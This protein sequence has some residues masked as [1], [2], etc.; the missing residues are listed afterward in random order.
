MPDKPGKPP[1][2]PGGKPDV[3]TGPGGMKV[4]G[5]KV[6]FTVIVLIGGAVV[7]GL[8]AFKKKSS[9]TAGSSEE[10]E[11]GRQAF[12]PVTAEN[13]GGV[14]A[15]GGGM[16]SGNGAELGQLLTQQQANSEWLA[17]FLKEQQQ[18][19]RTLYE[20]LSKTLSGGGAPTSTNPVGV[21]NAPPQNGGTPPAAPNPPP[22]HSPAPVS[23]VN[24]K[25]GNGCAGHEYPHG[26]NGKGSRTVECQ[27]K[28]NGKC[29]W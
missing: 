11:L 19:N 10:A 4:A 8:V 22:T 25:C 15:G 3:K 24:I 16:S 2:K 7:V 27:T 17:E 5:K 12:I 6:P 29:H 13:V 18:E 20:T 23:P 21:V 28:T 9:G 26:K 14:G 1:G